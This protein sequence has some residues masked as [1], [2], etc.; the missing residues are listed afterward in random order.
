[1]RRREKAGNKRALKK[2]RITDL[3]K[4]MSFDLEKIL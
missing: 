2:N 3:N 4:R 1:V